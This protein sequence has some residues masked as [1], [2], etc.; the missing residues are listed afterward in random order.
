MRILIFSSEFPPGPGGIGAH[1]HNL[2]L[3][4]MV[5]GHQV[6]IYTAARS[7]YPG[8]KFDSE[9]R[10]EICRYPAGAGMLVRLMHLLK[11]LKKHGRVID[12]VILSGL[13]NL[14][15]YN[16]IRILIKSRVLC[17]VHGHEIIMAKGVHRF[18]V[19]SALMNSDCVVAVSDFS[20]KLLHQNGI[21]RSIV[22]IPNGVNMIEGA[23]PKRRH[24]GKLI[25]ITVGSVT[26]RKGQHNVV[27]ALPEIIKR[28][29]NVEYHI[30]G[31][32]KQKVAIESLA[33]KLGVADHIF[34]HGA[35][36]DEQRNALMSQSDIF[37]MLS[38]NLPDGDVEGFGIAVL[39]ANSLGLPS[40]GSRGTGV[41]QA[42]QNG[43]SGYVVDAKD[44]VDICKQMEIILK[45]YDTLSKQ[46]YEWAQKHDWSIIGKQYIA[47][48]EEN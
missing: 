15:L 36:N 27:S 11:F 37:M 10:A 6:I 3:Q 44:P 22:T 24:E 1:A 25:L 7:E 48:V 13:T 43:I 40:L 16:L 12:W 45:N 5:N 31:I 8:D 26:K 29:G 28:F 42:I 19:R 17:V 30:V 23:N 20:K 47:E 14:V 46:A 39:E 38:E 32:P 41:E 9:Q 4:L 33:Q 18:F 2:A 35:V 34:L 21:S